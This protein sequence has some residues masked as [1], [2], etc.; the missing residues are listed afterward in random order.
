MVAAM[1]KSPVLAALAL[2]L[3]AAPAVAKPPVWVVRDADSTLVIFGSMHVLPTGTDWRPAALIDAV[4]KADDLWFELP[5]DQSTQMAVAQ[6]AAVKGKLPPG[7]TLSAKLD[8]KTKARLAKAQADLGVPPGALEPFQPWFAEIAL[9]TAVFAK[10]GATGSDGVEATIA[11]E[12]PAKAQRKAFETAEEQIDLFAGAPM[13]DQIASLKQTLDELDDGPAAFTDLLKAWVE[14][15]IKGLQE[16]AVE[17][18][19]R[20][21]PRLY[22]RL[23]ADRNARWTKLLAERMKGAGET[24]VVVGAGHLVGQDGVPARLRA[25][26]FQVEG[27]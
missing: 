21:S 16:N 2:L 15:D 5:I 22:A 8:A 10:H 13:A 6:L 17:P 23:I 4:G 24:V 19:R 18:V 27:P 25:L 7:Q 11:R 1:R 14:G 26:G 20:A 3:A 12:A 9:A